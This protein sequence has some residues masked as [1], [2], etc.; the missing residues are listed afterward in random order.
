MDSQGYFS[1]KSPS[2][3]IFHVLSGSFSVFLHKAF[4]EIRR[5]GKADHIHDFR[6]HKLFLGKKHRS[7]F[8]PYTFY[9]FNCG[10]AGQLFD[11]AI[12]LF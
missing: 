2:L 5:V 11:T 9:L 4:G 8:H 7:L 10:I 6:N 12:N 3:H 1:D